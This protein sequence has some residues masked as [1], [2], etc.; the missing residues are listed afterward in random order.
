MMNITFLIILPVVIQ[1]LLTI[2][3]YMI[4]AA[5]KKRAAASGNVN[6]QR[7]GLYD[8]AWPDDVLQ[9]NNCIHNQFEVP[10]LFYV[11]STLLIQLN[12]GGYLAAVLAWLFVLS[13]CLHAFIHIGSNIITLRRRVFMFG[14]VMVLGMALLLLAALFIKAGV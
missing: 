13:R 4:L 5:R 11:V 2:A 9:V 10:V 1:I 7:R 3:L 8:D 14:V 6:E 12:A